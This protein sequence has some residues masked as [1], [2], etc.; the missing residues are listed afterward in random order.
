MEPSTG[1]QSMDAI[2]ADLQERLQAIFAADSSGHD[3]HHTM[4][5]YRLA[6]RIAQEEQA[7][8]DIV[9]LAA[10]LHDVDDRKLSPETCR[11]KAR[12]V[13]LMREYG[14]EDAVIQQVRTILDEV[15]F[16]GT[17]SVAPS[18]IEGMCVQDADRLDAIGA[19]GIGR[20]FAFG[21]SRGRAMY[22]PEEAPQLHMDTAA[23]AKSQSCTIN[24]FHEK[25]FLL[26]DMMNTRCAKALAEHRDQVMHAFVDEFLAEWN[27]V[28]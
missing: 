7:D 6:V 4:R 23:Y 8:I 27:G 2:L 18:T 12:A 15:S 1:K 3:Y 16:Q 25:L 14:F 21:G 20:A 24:H 28:V 13:A 9:S 11:D 19:I 26:K 22:L 10:L 5:V 17:D